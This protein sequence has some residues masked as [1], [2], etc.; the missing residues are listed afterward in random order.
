MSVI[1]EKQCQI[2]ACQNEKIDPIV[3]IEIVIGS[4]SQYVEVCEFHRK[5]FQETPNELL[6]IGFTYRREV[7]VRP[8]PA[9][10]TAP[11]E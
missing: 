4:A 10:P 3:A 2:Y 1:N 7:E 9:V 11:E 5:M 6:N 8:T